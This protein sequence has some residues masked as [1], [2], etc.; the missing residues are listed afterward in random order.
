MSI[1]NAIGSVTAN[2][3]L[4]MAI[5]IICIPAV[6]KRS[7]YLIKSALMLAAAV[8]IVIA[9][10]SGDVAVYFSTAI[11]FR[12]IFVRIEFA[13][14]TF[15]LD[16]CVIISWI[17]L[18]IC[19]ANKFTFSLKMGAFVREQKPLFYLIIC[20]CYWQLFFH[21]LEG[22]YPVILLSGFFLRQVLEVI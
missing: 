16:F 19:P 4:I 15:P 5:S 10:S 7:D 1:G 17:M 9:G 11:P 14:M 3:G 2:I 13:M 18:W 21:G 8:L 22:T 20:A 12:Y 6:I